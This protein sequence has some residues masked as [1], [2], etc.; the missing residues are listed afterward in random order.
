MYIKYYTLISEETMLMARKKKT[1]IML[2]QNGILS[3]HILNPH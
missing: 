1:L 3:E 2:Q